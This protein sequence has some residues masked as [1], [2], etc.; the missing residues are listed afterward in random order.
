MVAFPANPLSFTSN[1]FDRRTGA[2]GG[3]AFPG[4]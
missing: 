2:G 4:L 1:T 3:A